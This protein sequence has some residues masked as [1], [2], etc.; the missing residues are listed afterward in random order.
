GGGAVAGGGARARSW[1]SFAGGLGRARLRPPAF[2]ISTGALFETGS[3][4]HDGWYIGSGYDFRLI[5]NWIAGF[6]YRHYQLDSRLHVVTPALAS[7]DRMIKPNWN[8]WMFR[9]SYKFGW[10][11]PLMARY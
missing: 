3:A 8:S 10:A 2:L 1:A 9:L 4:R 6:E 5:G 11:A 7:D